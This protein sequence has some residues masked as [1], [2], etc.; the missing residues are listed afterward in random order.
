[1]NSGSILKHVMKYKPKNSTD[2]GQLNMKWWAV[3]TALETDLEWLE[4]QG[5]WECCQKLVHR[6]NCWTCLLKKCTVSVSARVLTKKVKHAM[7]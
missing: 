4:C 3:R 2:I 5:T 7:S 1:M 6:E